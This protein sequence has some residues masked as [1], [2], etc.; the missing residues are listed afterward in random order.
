MKPIRRGRVSEDQPQRARPWPRRRRDIAY[1]LWV[2]FLMATAA[3]VVFFAMVDPELL[4]GTTAPG[5]EISRKAG[6][7]IGFCGF[8]LLTAS[9]AAFVIWLIRTEPKD[10][11]AA[12]YRE[13]PDARRGDPS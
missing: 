13:R 8:W 2:S 5:W 3:F 7:G 4:S 11:T 12:A 10:P 9:T 1:A 6:Y